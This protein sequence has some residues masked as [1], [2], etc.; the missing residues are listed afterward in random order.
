M[1]SLKI[2]IVGAT[3]LVGQTIIKVLD[4]EGLLKT[5][6]I[7]LYVSKRSAG[8]E[9]LFKGRRFRLV[10]LD[11]KALDKKFDIVFFSAG[12][13]VSRVW[14]KRFAEKGA[15]VIDNT[16]EFR[17]CEDVPLV[18]PEINGEIV[19]GDAKIISN[20][21]CTTIELAVVIDKL[22]KLSKIKKL[23]VSTY[24]SVSG[25][26]RRAVCD[27]KNNAK[28]VFKY[29]IND[30][31]IAKIGKIQEN[32]YAEEEN[33]I[34]FE[35]SKIL[36]ESIDVSATAVRVPVEVCH[37]ESVYVK[38]ET[39]VNLIDVYSI[40]ESSYIK[41]FPDEICNVCEV[42]NTNAVSVFR[43]RQKSKTELEF[44]VLADNLRRGA[45]YN[46]VL[47]MKKLIDKNLFLCD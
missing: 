11:E 33:K 1:K 7:L 18:V 2:A 23:V 13:S 4:E 8:K 9:Y 38:F 22:L 34:M 44:F 15:F 30:N 12:S 6:D 40:L 41:V 24:Q 20:P 39:D 47:I 5:N 37:G 25:A 36:N 26:G 21:N 27:L 17:K 10:E 46:A 16:S 43:I 14:A 32:G 19:S 35:L 31:L 29:G 45:A 3:G 42:K 28:N